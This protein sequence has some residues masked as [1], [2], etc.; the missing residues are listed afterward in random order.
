[1]NT[2]RKLLVIVAAAIW[3]AI[4]AVSWADQAGAAESS[5]YNFNWLDPDKKIYVLQNRRYVKANRLLLSAMAGIG[6]SNPYRQVFEFDPRVAYYFSEAFGI[7]V[8]HTILTNAENNTVEALKQASAGALPVVREIKTQYGA[9]LH[10]VPWYAKI[11]VFNQ[12]L[13]FDWYFSGGL[14]Q[15][16]AD[17]ITQA[18]T[19]AP[20]V[21]TPETLFAGFLGTGHQYHVSESFVVRIDFSGAFYSAP[22]FGNFG[23]KSWFSN[24]TFGIGAGL[25]L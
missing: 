24:Y 4:V 11:N 22:V 7:E 16:T 6:M 25:K 2:F 1:M 14:G 5:E 15:I 12:I 19:T 10:Y 18:T 3:L 21:A 17:L 8:F 9:L 13:Y 20:Q 23:E